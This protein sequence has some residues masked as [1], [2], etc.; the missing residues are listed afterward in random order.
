M[1]H[2]LVMPYLVSCKVQCLTIIIIIIYCGTT[3][4]VSGLAANDCLTSCP[5]TPSPP[6]NPSVKSE[7]VHLIHH[8]CNHKILLIIKICT[9]QLHRTAAY[10]E[11]L[12]LTV[13]VN[14]SLA[15]CVENES[16]SLIFSRDCSQL[17]SI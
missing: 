4:I 7:D 15:G 11:T 14:D 10:V 8:H 12:W 9:N 1:Q 2:I 16:P 17:G 13:P 6:H 3:Q 5:I